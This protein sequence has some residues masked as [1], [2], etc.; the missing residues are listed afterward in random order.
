MFVL[1]VR[2]FLVVY[3]LVNLVVSDKHGIKI[4]WDL[5]ALEETLHGKRMR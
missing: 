3:W 2:L 5:S 4:Y 1:K